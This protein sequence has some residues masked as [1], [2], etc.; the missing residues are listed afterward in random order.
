MSNVCQ[1]CGDPT[2]LLRSHARFCS[3][4]CRVRHHRR[5]QL[6]KPLTDR[7]RWVRR[8]AA[9]VPLDARTGRFASVTDPAT[10][11]SYEQARA[12]TAGVGLGFVLGDGIG[13]W[14]LDKC[15]NGGQLA[16]WAREV[17]DGIDAPLF[18]ERS[19]SGEGVHVFV[20]A[21]EGPGRRIRDGERNVEF[22]SAGRYI[23][24]TG[25]VLKL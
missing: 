6:P 19:Q 22:Y 4:R 5:T 18:V 8:N 2:N 20:H 14:D 16:P 1:E 15:L 25:D 3:P 11:C 21:A 17:L 12:S 23:A 7:A 10:W 24:V 9:K 13:C